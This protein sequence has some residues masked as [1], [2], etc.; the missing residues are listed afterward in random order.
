MKFSE[1]SKASAEILRKSIPLMVE[2]DIPPNPYNYALWY[3]FAKEQESDLGKQLLDKFP[4][5]GHY[6]HATSEALFFDYFVKHHLTQSP[7]AQ[8]ALVDLL[9]QLFGSVSKMNDGA[10]EYGESLRKTMRSLN[11]PEDS[12]LVQQALSQLLEDT[13]NVEKANQDFQKELEQARQEVEVLKSELA[14]SE[15][16][17]LVDELTKISNR[18]AFDIAITTALQDRSTPTCL[19]MLDLDHFKK[20]NDTFGHVMGD[21][22]LQQTG[23]IL[24]KHHS[25]KSHVARYGGEEFAIVFKGPIQEAIE[26]AETIRLTIKKIR[27]KQKGSDKAL[28]SVTVSIGIAEASPGEPVKALKVR[29]DEA[30]YNSKA[31]GR[32]QYT[33]AQQA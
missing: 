27:I 16:K 1:D 7:S 17:A 12:A 11:E 30:L 24:S 32:D 9:G 13:N 25:E 21:K 20:C 33:C 8:N 22:V 26:L 5:K 4:E 31:A 14:S 29:A 23:Q 15:K 10:Q 2:R 3:S 6:D 18:R 19:L 28:N